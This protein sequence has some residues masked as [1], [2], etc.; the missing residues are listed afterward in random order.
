[1]ADKPREVWNRRFWD[2]RGWTATAPGDRALADMLRAD[3]EVFHGGVL[4]VIESLSEDELDAAID[5]YHYFGLNDAAAAIREARLV[6][7]D[8]VDERLDHLY[9]AAVPELDTLYAA[10]EEHFRRNPTDFEPIVG[11]WGTGA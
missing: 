6:S 5:G 11:L 9:W 1:M 8:D 4:N 7:S 3:D 10:F 2:A